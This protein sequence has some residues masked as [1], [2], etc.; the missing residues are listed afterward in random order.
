MYLHAHILNSKSPTFYN[1]VNQ[2]KT[3][4]PK[5]END[6]I[7]IAMPYSDYLTEKSESDKQQI[8]VITKNSNLTIFDGEIHPGSNFNKILNTIIEF[9]KSN[10]SI[11]FY[12]YYLF[13]YF[14]RV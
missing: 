1:T 6:K 9:L 11:D 10:L 5:Y 8:F 3:I 7:V 14:L 2:S 13:I 4:A 12:L